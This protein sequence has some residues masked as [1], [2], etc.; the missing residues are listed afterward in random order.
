MLTH[1]SHLTSFLQGLETFPKKKLSQNFLIDANVVRNI[2]QAAEIKP[3]DAVLEI[4]P[5]PG[6]LTQELLRQGAHVFAIEKDPI[7]ARELTRLG[8]N[9]V[10]FEEDFLEF[11]LA[12]QLKDHAP[13]KIVANL[14]YHVTSPILGKICEHSRL[15]SSAFLMVQR[16]VA[17]RI[18][19]QKGTKEMSLLTLF[20]QIYSDPSLAIKF[21]SRNC[22]LPAP[23]VDSSV[24]ALHFREPRIAYPE[25]FM[26]WV[27]NAF[28][29]RRKMLRSTLL[30][31]QEP[32]ATLRPQDLSLDEWIALFEQAL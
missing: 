23:K 6:A 12:E 25:R 3:G 21:I 18:V 9:L 20:L 15:F 2:V 14:P 13:L 31:Q 17:Q 19:A 29:Q 11:P 8:E 32:Y 1:P 16:E 24:V 28:Q 10:V 5:G 4:G 30:I 26:V 27:R 7:F 22:Y